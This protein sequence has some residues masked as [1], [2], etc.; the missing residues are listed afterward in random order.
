[1]EPRIHYAK[2]TDGVSIAFWTMGEGMFLVRIPRHPISHVELEWQFP[3]I[4]RWYERL[5]GNRM[6]VRYDGR[7]SGLSERDVADRSLDALALGQK[8]VSDT[9]PRPPGGHRPVNTE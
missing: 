7:G 4:R 6:L 8:A 1:M 3:E 5:A 2:T 9:P